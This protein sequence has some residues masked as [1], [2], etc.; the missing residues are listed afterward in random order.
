[1][2]GNIITVPRICYIFY[3]LYYLVLVHVDYEHS[4]GLG[5]LHILQEDMWCYL[6]YMASN[7]G[8]YVNILLEEL[9]QV[10]EEIRTLKY[11]IHEPNLTTIHWPDRSEGEHWHVIR[12]G[13]NEVKGN[14]HEWM[15]QLNVILI[16]ASFNKFNL[17]DEVEFLCNAEIKLQQL[18]TI[19]SH[20]HIAQA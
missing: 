12:Y 6:G 7:I 8:L 10:Y 5:L 18:S 17:I 13:Y 16:P 19:K 11:N 15:T 20:T 1:M 3:F 4:M 14:M 9:T 2:S